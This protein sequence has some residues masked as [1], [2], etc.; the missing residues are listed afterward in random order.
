MA[1]GQASPKV[2]KVIDIPGNPP[3]I[4]TAADT[5]AGGTVS[6]P[7]TAGS[8]ATGGPVSYYR[9]ISN[10]G[11]ITVNGTTSP[12]TVTGLTDGTAYTFSVAGV[13]A[14]GAGPFSAASNSATPTVPPNSFESIA[15]AT[16]TGSS[17]TISFTSIPSTYKHLQIRGT[18][19]DGAGYSVRMRFNSDTGNN[20]AWHRITGT[21]ASV[22]AGGAGGYSEMI[23]INTNGNVDSQPASLIIDIHDYA[24]TTK[25]KTSRTFD[26]LG[27]NNTGGE[28][29][30]RSGL[31][32]STSAITRIDILTNGSFTNLT[33]LALY[34][35]KGA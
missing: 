8:T 15:S 19:Y 5:A 26:G 18:S 29:E 6:V 10:P 33:R 11:S 2:G 25:Y 16:G 35:I 23:I 24:S 21:G 22:T 12:I 28:V 30:L 3:T 20:Y 34:G 17:G 7:F 32:Q 9:A 1:T 4:G 27:Q 31:W 14:T 13:N